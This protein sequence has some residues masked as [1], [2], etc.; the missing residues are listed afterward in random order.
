[1]KKL[2]YFVLIICLCIVSA[3]SLS[4]CGSSAE[5]ER[6]AYLRAVERAK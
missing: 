4:G 1:M 6:Q 5:A 3:D 2:K